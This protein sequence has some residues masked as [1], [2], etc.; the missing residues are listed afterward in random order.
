[1]SETR[2]PKDLLPVLSSL[3][4]WLREE[5]VSYAIIGGVAVGLVA[6]A[7]ATQDID[8]VV[9]LDL[10]NVAAFIES[11]A[12]FGF[13]PRVSDPVDFARKSRVVL[14]QHAD[15]SIGVDISCGALPFEQ[16]L[17][18]RAQEFKVREVTLNVASPEDLIITKAVAHR[19]RDLIDIESLVQAHPD[20]DLA[21]VR[22]WVQQFADV[23][24]APEL[25]NDL[26]NILRHAN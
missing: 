19:R 23:L 10:A 9:W 11:G 15:T 22:N 25:I 3:A 20:L 12:R 24:E 16:E 21:R 13:V 6:E 18:K 1:M 14:L 4:E 7:R 5:G 2:P 26:E 17:I 8:A